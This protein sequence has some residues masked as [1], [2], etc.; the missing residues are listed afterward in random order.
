MTFTTLGTTPADQAKP[1]E[2]RPST[3]H[4][5]TTIFSGG[6]RSSAIQRFSDTVHLLTK[7]RTT[8]GRPPHPCKYRGLGR[9]PFGPMDPGG[10]WTKRARSVGGNLHISF[11]PR[12]CSSTHR[13]SEPV[14]SQ[15]IPMYKRPP[16]VARTSF[17]PFRV[18]THYADDNAQQRTTA[19]NRTTSEN[20]ID[21]Q[22]LFDLEVSEKCNESQPRCR[23]EEGGRGRERRECGL[24]LA[25]HPGLFRV[26]SALRESARP[27]HPRSSEINPSREEL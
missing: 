20:I 11:S 10:G 27:L 2:A 6:T 24:S 9:S 21:L 26:E 19:H 4:I 14:L 16:S 18:A 7:Y 1:D 5:R 25:E 3:L 12:R 22:S 13:R 17:A 8:G 15:S 23:T